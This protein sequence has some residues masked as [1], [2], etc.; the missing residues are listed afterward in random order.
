[1]PRRDAKEARQVSREL[2]QKTEN[3]RVLGDV[4]AYKVINYTELFQKTTVTHRR[5]IPIEA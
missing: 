2:V 3:V 1:M 5:R 4:F